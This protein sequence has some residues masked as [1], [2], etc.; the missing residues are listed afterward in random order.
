MKT[1]LCRHCGNVFKETEAIVG[2]DVSRSFYAG[3]EVKTFR[4]NNTICGHS[5]DILEI[6][7]LIQY[8]KKEIC[9][10]GN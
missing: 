1:F 2:T 9:H 5:N 3:A 6:T 8:I 10:K 7:P 4:C